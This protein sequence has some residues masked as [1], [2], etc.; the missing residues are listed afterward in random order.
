MAVPAD[1]LAGRAMSPSALL[2]S[3]SLFHQVFSL[4]LPVALQQAINVG[5][6]LMDTLMLGRL[7]EIQLSASS[8]ANTYYMFFTILC[9][10][11]VGGCG[12]L[13]SQYWGAGQIEKV[14]RT[15]NLALKITSLICIVFSAFTY[16]FA[17]KIMSVMTN[18]ET[19]VLAGVGYLRI[20]AFIF[21]FH[22]LSIVG[23][24]LM[25][26]VRQVNLGA[27]SS[28][29]S[30]IVNFFANWVFIYGNLGA[31][32]MEICGAALGT[33]I[34]RITEFACVYVFLFRYDDLVHLTP[35]LLMKKIDKEILYNYLHLGI[36]AL[37]S[38]GL[39]GLGGIM[40][41]AVLGHMGTVVVSAIA[42][43]QVVE[44][45]FMVTLSGIGSAATVM[46]GNE[47]GAGENVTAQSMGKVFFSLSISFGL[48]CCI[49]TLIAGNAIV[50]AYNITS[51]TVQVTRQIL[52]LFSFFV[53]FH[54]TDTVMN[55]G[56]LRGGGDT[57]KLMYMDVVF[58]WCFG[59]P[60]GCLVGLVFHQSA[61][62]TV[63]CIRSEWLLKSIW[64][65]HRLLS[66][67][68]I[69]KTRLLSEKP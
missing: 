34:A 53:I 17:V 7:G 26:S 1:I 68:W 65:L 3:K 8:L 51:E 24:Q 48:V 56:V 45:F 13:A 58:L 15:F 44:R 52:I 36:P 9:F 40:V 61:W 33:L 29:I 49:L 64:S 57:K 50:A 47:V 30:F 28:L 10:G 35:S 32:R 59:L 39:L 22:G 43:C 4:M 11:I 46:V 16:F 5:V 12:V 6:N 63:L 62:L 67:K 23:A 25:R 14:Q 41:S 31:P 27:Y 19:V 20:T 55:K 18:D 2:H 42:I 60:L 54:S 66:Q 37:V 21:I 69:H 38:D